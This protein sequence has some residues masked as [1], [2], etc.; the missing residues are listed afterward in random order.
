MLVPSRAPVVDT[1][2]ISPDS[3]ITTSSALT[4]EATASDPDGQST[5]LSYTWFNGSNVLGSGVNLS[6][7][8]SIAQP[9]DSVT[10]EAT[11]S[12]TSGMQG[13][14]SVS[15]SVD[16]SAPIVSNVTVLPAAP[17]V[18][19]RYC[20]CLQRSR[21]SVYDGQLSV[22]QCHPGHLLGNLCLS[23]FGYHCGCAE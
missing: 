15:V 17:Y 4:C 3:G 5:S 22:A 20:R 18:T 23:G 19:S 2:A 10:C 6:L 9:G 11:A 1:M 21:W 13:I 7:D 14:D 12:D 16:N 8:S